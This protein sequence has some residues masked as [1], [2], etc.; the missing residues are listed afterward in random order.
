MTPE[1]L[2][3]GHKEALDLEQKH[4]DWDI[5]FCINRHSKWFFAEHQSGVVTITR[6]SAK[7]LDHVL[8]STTVKGR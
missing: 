3:K 6:G 8:S 4:P 1:E 7:Q 5:A 2:V